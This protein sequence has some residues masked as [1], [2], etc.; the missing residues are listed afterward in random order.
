MTF[1]NAKCAIYKAAV[2]VL[3][4]SLLNFFFR[5][6]LN[7]VDLCQHFHAD[8]VHHILFKV[9]LSSSQVYHREN[10]QDGNA[11]LRTVISCS[12]VNTETCI[13]LVELEKKVC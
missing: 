7:K 5:R 1:I 10:G 3:V 8:I 4:F 6:I 2:G 13:F 11:G 9:L 12:N